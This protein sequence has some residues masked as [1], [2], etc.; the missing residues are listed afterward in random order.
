MTA[1]KHLYLSFFIFVQFYVLQIWH[2]KLHLWGINSA[3]PINEVVFSCQRQTTTHDFLLPWLQ[4]YS[5][6]NCCKFNVEMERTAAYYMNSPFGSSRYFMNDKR[7]SKEK[8]LNWE[9]F[10]L[11]V[12]GYRPC[13]LLFATSCFIYKT[14]KAIHGHPEIRTGLAPV[15]LKS[16][17]VGF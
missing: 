16:L 8:A 6:C 14:I 1:S 7:S 10:V 12:Q 4:P 5:V 11:G 9:I 2:R 17:P 3:N 15:M 13:P